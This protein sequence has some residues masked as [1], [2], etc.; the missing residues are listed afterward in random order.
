M[1]TFKNLT[2]FEAKLIAKN[3][4]LRYVKRDRELKNSNGSFRFSLEDE[5][6]Y[7]YNWWRFFTPI[8][9]AYV[10]NFYGYSNTTRKHQYKM[11]NIIRQAKLMGVQAEVME[12]NSRESLETY[13]IDSIALSNLVNGIKTNIDFIM[14]PRKHKAN[15]AECVLGLMDIEELS[16]VKLLKM[17]NVDIKE[18][19]DMARKAV[20]E[21]KPLLAFHKRHQQIQN[22]L[23]EKALTSEV[24]EWL[25]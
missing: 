18:H 10:F 12:L 20:N 11:F 24:K 4:G 15:K 23:K 1:K 7:S 21:F 17:L 2:D 13:K 16:E 9:G 19:L 22:E 8:K 6:A 25:D 3:T 14:T 5:R